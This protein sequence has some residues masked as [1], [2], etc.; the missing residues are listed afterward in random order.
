MIF[1]T[2]YLDKNGKKSYEIFTG[3]DNRKIRNEIATFAAKLGMNV[4]DFIIFDDNN[5]TEF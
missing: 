5:Q 1:Y 4:S 2:L 3:N